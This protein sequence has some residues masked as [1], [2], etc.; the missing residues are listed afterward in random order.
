MLIGVLALQGGYYEHINHLVQLDI[1]YCLIKS[2]D[3]LKDIDGLIIPGGESTSI[4]ILLDSFHLKETIINRIASGL[5]VWG[6]CAGL[7]SIAKH[8][9]GQAPIMPLMAISVQRNAYGSQLASFTT[10]KAISVVANHE[11]PL[12]F[13]RAPWIESVEPTV[14]VL[15][16][17]N[18]RIIMARQN[19]M[20]V[21]TFHPEL[22]TDTSVLKYFI[23][24][25]KV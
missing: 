9:S 20:L 15:A 1:P 19:N 18:Q 6:T 22:T 2:K 11:I 4:N 13:I 14:C 17:H 12:V 23:S 8:I 16:T 5:C 3:D 7:I 25:I 10:S 24:M 21:T